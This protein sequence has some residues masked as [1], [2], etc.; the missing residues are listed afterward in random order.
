MRTKISQREAHRLRRA[1]KLM[2]SA[3]RGTMGKY[4]NGCCIHAIVP[5]D[6]TKGALHTAYML[7]QTVIAVLRDNEVKF[8]AVN[9]KP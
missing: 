7:S 6:M 9:L 5:S 8:I 2:E 3:L 1:N 4:P